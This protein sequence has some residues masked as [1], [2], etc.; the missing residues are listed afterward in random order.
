M[1][2]VAINIL[3]SWASDILLQL[4]RK[5]VSISKSKLISIFEKTLDKKPSMISKIIE[6]DTEKE[7][8]DIF[9]EILGII[10][11]SAEDGS[12]EINSEEDKILLRSI[13]S[14]K[15][16]HARGF[17][18]MYGADIKSDTIITGGGINSTGETNITNTNMSTNNT[19]ISISKGASIKITGNASMSQH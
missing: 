7:K 17:I 13:T 18:N 4:T 1:K 9:T 15:L 11:L 19:Q 16:D 6:A 10:S 2:E 12:I 14:I 5:G 8:E 3:T